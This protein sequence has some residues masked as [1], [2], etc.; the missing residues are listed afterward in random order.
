VGLGRRTDHSDAVVDT[1]LV[2]RTQDVLLGAAM[3]DLLD[4]LLPAVRVT[5]GE[6]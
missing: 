2:W 5:R 4:E 3:V 6:A 1:V